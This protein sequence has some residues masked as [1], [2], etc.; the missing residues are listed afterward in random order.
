[1]VSLGTTEG[2][3]N[4]QSHFES[5]GN[6]LSIR[7]RALAFSQ[8][9]RGSAEFQR[10]QRIMPAFRYASLRLSDLFARLELLEWIREEIAKVP[11]AERIQAMTNPSGEHPWMWNVFAG[12]AIKDF[13]T[14]VSS[15]MDAIAQVVISVY[16]TGKNSGFADIQKGSQRTYRQRLPEDSLGIIDATDSWWPI[17]KKVRDTLV[18]RDHFKSVFPG[19]GDNESLLFLAEDGSRVPLVTDQRLMATNSQN[20]VDLT[21]YTGLVV[22]QLIAFMDEISK[23]IAKNLNVSSP[24]PSVRLGDFRRLMDSWENLIKPQK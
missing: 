9:T 14:D 23:D 10:I 16:D 15:T 11:E 12:L 17:I 6:E 20:V 22:A 7:S 21:L 5:L 3:D 18:H 19:L 8:A 13:H 1:M 4:L 2:Q 24:T